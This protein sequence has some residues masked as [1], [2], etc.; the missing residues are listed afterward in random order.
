[1]SIRNIEYYENLADKEFIDKQNLELWSYNDIICSADANNDIE[2]PATFRLWTS[3]VKDQNTTSTCAAFALASLMETL[4]YYDTE[5]QHEF[6]TSW[7]Y[8]YRLDNHFKGDG[9]I[10]YEALEMLQKVGAVHS[11]LM[12]DNFNYNESKNMIENMKDVCLEEAKNYKIKN[13][14]VVEGTNNI[15]RTLFVDK[16]PVVISCNLY[17]NFYRI[18]TS[19]ILPDKKDTDTFRGWHTMLIVGWTTINDEIY[20]VVKNSYGTDW[21][22]NGYCYIKASNE[23]K[24]FTTC[25][26][27]YDIE[28]YPCKLTD[29][30]GRWSE[31]F[32]KRTVKT[33]IISGYEDNTF[34]PTNNLTREEMCVI[35]CRLL[36]KM[37]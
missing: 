23:D 24:F 9:M 37:K 33:G 20:F 2:Y 35:I 31:D 34:R 8:G 18:N 21:G 32:I 25:Y 6:S 17:S 14:A 36:D 10:T 26:G 13:Y 11:S 5:D 7:I 3:D 12:P 28:N 16:S 30:D 1:M 19:G 29:I 27:V 4:A 15:M 22:D